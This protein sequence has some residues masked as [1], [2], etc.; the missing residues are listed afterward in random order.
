MSWLKP[1][2][3]FSGV[4][5]AVLTAMLS[6]ATAAPAPFTLQ[7]TPV[8]YSNP[9]E[10]L[11]ITARPSNPEQLSQLLVYY[12]A[13]GKRLFDSVPMNRSGNGLY[14][15]VIPAASIPRAGVVYFIAAR[16][17]NG[18]DYILFASPERPHA[19]SSRSVVLI[20]SADLELYDDV[21]KGARRE[22]GSE[23]K[24]FDLS[25]GNGIEKKIQ[26]KLDQEP[27]EVVITLGPK[28]AQFVR[29]SN[30]SKNVPVIY[31]MVS[32][33]RSS[34]LRQEK[35]TG[36]SF[37]ISVRQ[38]LATFKSIIP[39]IKKVG[40][41]YDPKRTGT[42]VQEAKAL[43]PSLGFEL[44]ATRIEESG[45]VEPTLRAFEKSI[46]AFWLIPDSTVISGANYN[47]LVDF[48]R[49][50]RIPLFVFSQDLVRK[51]ALVALSPDYQAIGAQTGKLVR[52]VLEGN[53]PARLPVAT[54]EKM[55]VTLN[56]R[57]ARDLRL[58]G[59]AQRIVDYAAENDYPL[60]V[61]K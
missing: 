20:K 58:E 53:D 31:S 9:Y 4:F 8:L 59:I 26:Q 15:G 32:N 42:M 33:P 37:D 46:D 49:Q 47:R 44:L 6:L 51:G 7:H 23:I 40:V 22:I 36:V 18:N 25:L 41:I 14:T 17:R 27:P 24:E 1:Q 5:I 11:V 61:Y 43:A 19:V 3:T 2:N 35:S 56:M 12:R 48:S 21:I 38:S 60:R 57:T 10:D 13:A 34:E 30:F 39:N 28:A 52:R 54:P 55:N 16:D 50:Y 45:E 29:A